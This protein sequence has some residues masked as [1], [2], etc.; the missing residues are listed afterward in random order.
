MDLET[1]MASIHLKIEA[2]SN[3]NEPEDI[4][5]DIRDMNRDFLKLIENAELL[6]VDMSNNLDN[7][8]QIEMKNNNKQRRQSILNSSAGDED[9]YMKYSKIAIGTQNLR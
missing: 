4:D 3:K 2:N 5:F 7:Q 8:A 9:L 1:F 6:R